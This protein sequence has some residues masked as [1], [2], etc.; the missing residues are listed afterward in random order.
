MISF[1]RDK[2]EWV[3]FW[4]S[5]KNVIYNNDEISD[6]DNFNYLRSK[7]VGEARRNFEGFSL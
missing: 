1:G 5:C 3:E 2:T 6:I 4:E 7:L